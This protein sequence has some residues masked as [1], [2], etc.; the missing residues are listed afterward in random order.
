MLIRG[1]TC[2]VYDIESFPNF[3]SVTVK[4][5]ESHKAKAYEISDRRNDLPEIAKLFLN[6]NI[7]WVGYNSMHYDAPIISYLLINYKKLILRPVWEITLEVKKFSDKIVN[8]ETS[9]SWSLYK[10]A[11]LFLD[12]DLLAMR[13]SQKL[14]PSLKALQVTMEYH[15]VEEF[16]GDFNAPISLE[17]IPRVL[18]YNLND[19][20]ATEEFL[21]RC[22][23]DIELRI[24][25]EDQYHISALNKDGVNLGMEIIKKYYLDKTG[26][27]WGEIKDLRSKV[28]EIELKDV[29]FDYIEFKTPVLQNVLKQL[30]QTTIPITNVPKGYKFE[31]KFEIGGVRH[32]YGIGGLHSENDPEVFE[33]TDEEMLVDSDV[34]SLY[35]SIILKNKLFPAH[36]G[37]AF[38]DVYNTI[39]EQRVSAKEEGRQIENETL[40]LA[41]NGLT[42]NLQSIYSWVYDP[43]MVFRIRINGQLMLLMLIESVVEHGFRLIQSNTD[44]IFVKI[45][46]AKYNEYKDVCWWWE[47]KTGLVLEHD[48]FE[49]FYQYAI[50]DYLGVKKGWSE[51]HNQKYIKKKGLFIN[52]P[53]LGKGLAPMIIADAID[54]Y[55]VNGTPIEETIRSCKDIKKFCT[56]QKPDKIFTVFY[57]DKPVT[58]INRYYMSMYGSIIYKQ[59]V[60][61]DGQPY[62]SP[63]AL[64]ADSPV[65]IYNRF[66]NTPIEKRGINY[67]YYI[68]EAYKIIEK[69]NDKQLTLW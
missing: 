40:K 26:K 56:Y 30:K 9:A 27:S 16:S 66:D 34:R 7:H 63:I 31:I 25:I 54:D 17:D 6:H 60:G 43:M 28:D 13:W 61:N 8:S 18:A 14:R 69:L 4:N 48:E 37:E 45:P 32:T 33:P 10:Y 2:F 46:K 19:V 24:A 57:G 50:N 41:L 23:K 68:S 64:C 67:R 53:I 22:K 35:P 47:Q 55:L 20:E 52:E 65:T 3:L 44:G 11:N 42:G 36:L 49:R 1:K 58:H 62:G 39:Y 5:T 51:T 38:L 15:N 59:R 12:L 21:N 29:I